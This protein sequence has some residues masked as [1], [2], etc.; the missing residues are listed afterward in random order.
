M[1]KLIIQ[2]REEENGIIAFAWEIE[3]AGIIKIK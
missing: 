3:I 1:I 2:L